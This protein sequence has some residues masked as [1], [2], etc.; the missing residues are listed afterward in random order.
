MN[1]KPRLALA[2]LAIVGLMGTASIGRAQSDDDKIQKLEERIVQLEARVLILEKA[3]SKSQ[4]AAATPAAGAKHWTVPEIKAA[5]V[6]K[7]PA[8]IKTL[9]GP[10]DQIQ[11]TF[12]GYS[13][14]V[15]ADPVSG[16]ELNVLVLEFVGGKS[17]IFQLKKG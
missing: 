16:T 7:V 4:A 12:W 11:N 9:L 14:M 5:C 15:I 1:T 13:H 2:T 10:P 8:E 6:G 17:T 3:V